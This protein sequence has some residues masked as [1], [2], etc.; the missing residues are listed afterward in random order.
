MDNEKKFKE[1]VA[2]F[3]SVPA[4]EL[5][6]DMRFREDLELSSLDF[7]TFLGD[8]EDEFDVELDVTQAQDITTIGEAL[9]LMNRLLEEE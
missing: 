1:L 8:L 7:M 5:T 9:D 3:C 6:N 4:D 2:E